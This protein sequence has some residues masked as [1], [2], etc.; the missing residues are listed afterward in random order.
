MPQFCPRVALPA[1]RQPHVG[2]ACLL[3]AILGGASGAGRGA[4][5]AS[6][7]QVE[8]ASETRDYS[9]QVREKK[10]AADQQTY[11]KTILLPQ[12]AV[13]ANRTAIARTRQ[14]LRELALRDAA[15]EVFD[16]INELLREEMVKQAADGDAEPLVRVN[17][18]LL[19][20]DL[21]GADGKPWPGAAETLAR[22]SGDADL[23]LAVRVAALAGL[24]NHV[25]A[26][27]GTPEIA[28][29]AGPA[30]TALLATPPDGDP[31][32]RRWLLTRALDLLPMVA[33][34]PAAVAAAAAIVADKQADTD[35][36]VRAAM[37]LGKLARP[38]AG[39]DAAAA[40]TEI[41]E[42]AIA[43]LA[44]D[45]AAAEDRRFAKK[46]GSPDSRA[47]D[48][49]AG[50][51]G[52]APPRRPEFGGGGIFGGQFGGDVGGGA[53]ELLPEDEDAVPPLACRR[54]AWRLYVLAEA[55]SPARSG[56]GLAEL[57][58]GDAQAAAGDLAAALRQAALDL[59]AQPDERTLE[60]ALTT[61]RQ[62]AGAAAGATED[63]PP[64]PKATTEGDR[65]A[66]PF[67]GPAQQS[68]F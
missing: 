13:E 46:L 53:T 40:V 20:G 63:A 47:G 66:S 24:T 5:Y 54:E 62:A 35:V 59:D 3:A 55:I 48:M 44:A 17:A 36:R 31:V 27:A 33:P 10:F 1:R 21:V 45:L 56:P 43:A 52:F 34:P 8:A 39:I 60:Q 38:E 42:L 15:K 25:A 61:L 9:Q 22:G 65:P 30:V 64:E 12:L 67:E 23:P 4:D 26:A 19:V 68:P 58:A 49:G 50:P 14:R 18:M 32:A 16:P 57:L 51:G 37:A 2:V 11:L 41:R 29:V 28:A 7:S 6:L